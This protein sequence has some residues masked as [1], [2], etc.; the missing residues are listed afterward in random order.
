MSVL[1]NILKLTVNKVHSGVIVKDELGLKVENSD[2]VLPCGIFAR[3]Q[4]NK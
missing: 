3:W 4:N 2:I 1:E